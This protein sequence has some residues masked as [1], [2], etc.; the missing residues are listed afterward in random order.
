MYV[1]LV[2]DVRSDKDPRMAKICK[3][4]LIHIQNSVF[5]GD[6]TLGDLRILVDKLKKE[7]DQES[8]VLDIFILRSKSIVR[9]I[10]IGTSRVLTENV[11]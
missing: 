8:E 5:I 7:V 9:R 3:P 1:V 10:T 11:I 4:Y 2:Y 6:I